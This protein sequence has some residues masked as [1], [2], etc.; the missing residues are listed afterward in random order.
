MNVGVVFVWMQ[1]RECLDLS[2]VCAVRPCE[3]YLCSATKDAKHIRD[4]FESF[5]DHHLSSRHMQ[6]ALTW[7]LYHVYCWL[8]K[9]VC[10]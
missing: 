7:C 4:C 5:I 9:Y 2:S 8:L 6:S 3:L 1:V 10:V